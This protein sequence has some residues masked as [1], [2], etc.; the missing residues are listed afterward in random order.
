LAIFF[1]DI[2]YEARIFI[3]IYLVMLIH[4]SYFPCHSL[5]RTPFPRTCEFNSI[6]TLFSETFIQSG[7]AVFI[8][9][10]QTSVIIIRHSLF[11]QRLL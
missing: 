7:E 8:A 2:A 6:I 5:I 9:E 1:V 10:M 11:F 3:N 4:L